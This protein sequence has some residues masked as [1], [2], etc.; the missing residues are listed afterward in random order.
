[1]IYPKSRSDRPANGP[2][3]DRGSGHVTSALQCICHVSAEQAYRRTVHSWPQTLLG[4]AQRW[5]NQ[6]PEHATPSN[7]IFCSAHQNRTPHQYCGM[8]GLD[9]I[10]FYRLQLFP[11][12]WTQVFR[13]LCKTSEWA[14]FCFGRRWEQAFIRGFIISKYVKNFIMTFKIIIIKQLKGYVVNEVCA[15]NHRNFHE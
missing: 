5:A 12:V 2:F 15:K 13:I 4:E 10:C 7:R 11:Q 1:M 6:G 3:Q 14:W 9:R 8:F